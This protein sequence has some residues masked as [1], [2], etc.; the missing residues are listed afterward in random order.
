MSQNNSSAQVE[1]FINGSKK[2]IRDHYIS[3]LHRYASMLESLRSSSS[4]DPKKSSNPHAYKLWDDHWNMSVLSGTTR[5]KEYSLDN[6]ILYKIESQYRSNHGGHQ[7]LEDL[8]Q[9]KYPIVYSDDRAKFVARS[10]TV[11]EEH[12]HQ[13]II[14]NLDHYKSLISDIIDGLESKKNLPIYDVYSAFEAII[15]TMS[16]CTNHEE[17]TVNDSL[18]VRCAKRCGFDIHFITT[19]T[20]HF[21]AIDYMR[22]YRHNILLIGIPSDRKVRYDGNVAN[23]RLQFISHDMGHSSRVMALDD[24]ER[25]FE[26]YDKAINIEDAKIKEL[27]IMFLYL[28]V[29]EDNQNY[30]S[31]IPQKMVDLCFYASYDRDVHDAVRKYS[32]LY[33]ATDN[34]MYYGKP[35][36]LFGN[37]KDHNDFE[38]FTQYCYSHILI[39][40]FN[41]S[42]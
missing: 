30:F 41:V 42:K 13:F 35:Q 40:F 9:E 8:L 4:W 34:S 18:V 16:L 37:G 38:K 25:I 6:K 27:L 12:K 39:N 14:D 24:K 5:V 1:L 19:N 21:D 31:K 26:I 20:G 28:M 29:H 23:S 22:A 11:H 3:E 36:G 15:A 2:E 7:S 32:D 17:L 10:K 33:S